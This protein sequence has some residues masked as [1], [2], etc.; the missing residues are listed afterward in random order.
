MLAVHSM[1][2]R[3]HAFFNIRPSEPI[4]HRILKPAAIT[5]AWNA[6]L[7]TPK[8]ELCPTCHN[9]MTDHI[10]SAIP[11][12]SHTKLTILIRFLYILIYLTHTHAHWEAWRLPAD[13]EQRLVG[14]TLLRSEIFSGR[15][16]TQLKLI[17]LAARYFLVASFTLFPASSSLSPVFSTALSICLPAFSAGPSFCSR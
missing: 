16:S 3:P 12:N 14:A 15:L 17:Q 13:P 2:L 9:P 6:P 10:M 8:E 5:V 11:V 1:S 4:I 7:L